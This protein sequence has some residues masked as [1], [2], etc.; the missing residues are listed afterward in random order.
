MDPREEALFA[1]AAQQC[2]RRATVLRRPQAHPGEGPPPGLDLGQLACR[3]G[4]EA[5]VGDR[6]ELSD[7][8]ADLDIRGDAA[9]NDD[10]SRELRIVVPDLF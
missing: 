7:P 1:E 8:R 10:S 3:A 5:R 4:G 9:R 6:L 2:F